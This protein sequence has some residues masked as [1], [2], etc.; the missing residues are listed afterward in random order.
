MS[1]VAMVLV[2]CS[3]TSWSQVTGYSFA[4]T[5]GTY[6]PVTAGTQIITA[7]TDDGSS[8]ATN[9]GFSFTFNGTAFTQFV[10]NSNGSIRLGSAAP[11][12]QYT[13]ISTTGNT[14]AIA[15]FA[16]D[17]Q[18]VGGV[19][20]ELS[21]TAPNRVLTIEY[22]NFAPSYLALANVMNAQIKLYE[23]TNVVQIVYGSS[24]TTASYTGQVGLRGST[25]ASDYS[26]RLSTTSW[27]ASTAGTASSSTMTWSATVQPTSGQTYTWTPPVP[28]SGTPVA[29]SVAPASQSLCTGGTVA[30]LTVSG[31]TSGVTGLTFQWIQSTDGGLNYAPVI[32]GTGATTVTY[33]PPVFAGTPI[34]YA[35]RVT[36]SNG[37]AFA[38]STPA[39]VSTPANPTTQ[40]SALAATTITYNGATLGWTNG[41]G[42]RRVV[43]LS[44]SPI[45]DPVNGNMAAYTANTVYAGTG[46]QVILDGTAATVSVTG[47][48][49]GTTYYVGVYE[50]LRC[51]AGPYD[52][53]FNTSV[54]T[55]SIS[56][57]T[58]SAVSIPYSESFETATVPN[59]AACT[60]T[61]SHPLTRST[62]ATGAAPRT[63]T[64]YQNIRWT[65][66]VT[67]YLYSAALNLTG[68][69]S[70]DMGAWYLTDGIAGWTSIKLYANTA[71]SVTGATLLTTVNNAT[72]TSYQNIN[73]TYVPGIT[74]VYYFIIEVVH[75]SGPNDM[76]IDDLYAVPTPTC[77]VPT[78]LTV[79]NVTPN[80]A[81]V[82]WTAPTTGTTPVQYEYAVT[83][84]AT[85]PTSGTI[86]TGTSDSVSGLTANTT[87]YLHVRSEC[88]LGVDYSNWVT[89]ASFT[90]PATTPA[91][92]TESFATT[93]TP[94]G[95][96]NTGF[97]IGSVANF[98]PT[99]NAIYKNLYSGAT[100]GTF[101]TINVGPVGPG[102][103]LSFQY[104]L[105]DWGTG[106][107]TIPAAGTGNFV[108][109]VSTDF[110]STYT[111]LE[112]VV[113]DGLG[114]W[115]TKSYSLASYVGQYLKVRITGN[116]ITTGDYYLAFD[117]FSV[118]YTPITVSSFAPTAVCSA[119][120]ATSVVT[121]TGTNFTGATDVQ[122]N[123]VSH[124]FAVVNDTTITVNLTGT[125]TA[126]TFTVYNIYT[127]GS[128]TGSLTI[129]ASPVVSPITG[130]SNDLCM[131][132]TL[133]LANNTALGVWSSSDTAVA[134]INTSGEVTGV[135]EGT[136]TISY[137]VTDNGCSTAVTYTVNVKAPVAITTNPVN[138]SVVTGNNI[139]FTAAAT[140][141]GVSYQWEES[142]DGG[143]SYLPISN[144]GVYSGADTAVLTLTAVPDTMNGY[145]Y[146][147]VVSGTAPCGPETTLAA[148]LTVGNTGIATH[149]SNFTLCD[150]GTATF[151][152]VGSGPVVSYQWYQDAGL[153]P[154]PLVDGAG[155]SGA[156][157]DT[158]TLTGVDTSFNGYTY[159]VDVVGPANTSPSNSATLF[160]NTPATI[161]TDPTNQ[162]V[163]YSGGTVS[164]TAAAGGTF[165]GVQWQYSTDNTSWNNVAN[166]TPAG[167][168][169]NGAT[170]A[171]LNVTTTV[172]T[173]IGGTYYY[174]ML[175]DA[176]APCF[177]VPSASAQLLFNNPA[178]TTAPAAATVLAGNTATFTVVS[179]ATGTVTYQ[180]QRSTTL[181][182][183]YSNVVNATP[184]NVTYNGANTATL[185]VIT[186][187]GATAGAN[188]YY[189]VIVTSD[190][191][192]VTST[193]A[194]LTI[195]NYCN[196]TPSSNDASG[197]T[198][199]VLGATNFTIPDVTYSNQT[200]TPV[201]FVQGSSANFQ[202]TFATGYTYDSNVWIDMNDDGDFVDAGELVK[203]GVSLAT[204][205]TT[206]NLS[207][208]MPITTPV[209]NHRMRL[210][211]ADSGQATPNPCYTGSF[212]VTIDFTVTITAA[213]QCTGTPAV[214]VAA[215][216]AS[217]TCA[218]SS[219]NLTLSGI[220]AELGYTYQWY[221]RTLPSGSFA[222]IAGATTSTY[223]YTIPAS[224]EIYAT[225]T[226]TNSGLSA[227]SNTL[228]VTTTL[229]NYTV[230][231]NTG[232]TYNSVMTTGSTYTSL[233]SADDGKT[234]TVSLAGTT[235][236][237]NG[238]VVTGFYATSNGW[239]TFNTGQTSAT[240]TNDLTSTGQ[241]NV[242]APFWDDLVI[243]GNL[244]ANRDI[245]MR[246]QVIGTLGSGSA[247][248]VIEWAEM[249]KFNYGDPNINFQIVLHEADNSIDFNYG[250]MQL[251]NGATQNTSNGYYTYSV[252]MNGSVP[253]TNATTSRIM[254]Q[255]GNNYNFA[256]TVQNSLKESPDCN[257]QL[258]FVPSAAHVSGTAPASLIPTNNE[259]AGAITL[260][261]N[262]DPCTSNCG[263]IYTSKNATATAGIGV[264]TATTPGTADDDVFFTFT[265][266]STIQN[267][268]IEVQASTNYNPVVQ[269]LDASL[270]PVACFNAA[271]AGL[272]ELVSSVTLSLST[273][274][275]LRIYDSAT[276][277]AGGASGS[278]EFAVC[279]SQILPPPAYDE[280]A[281]ALSL[282]VGTTCS[283]VASVPAEIL[284]ST[285]T[286]GI[287]VC[288]A[289]TAGTPDDDVWYKFTTPAASSGI[290][291]TI[292]VQGISTF[293]PV[294]QLFAGTP[295]TANSVAC[296]N[297]TGNGGL[298]TISNSALLPSTD[299]YVRI[300]NSGA[301]AA[302]GS[303]TVCVLAS[304]PGCVSSPTAPANASTTCES[305][306]GTTLSWAAVS[307]ATLY[308]VYFEGNLVSAD[309]TALSWTTSVL[310][311]GTYSWSV[312]PKN[313]YGT[314]TACS[315]FTFTVL[316]N[317]TYYADL[318]NDGFG[319]AAVPVVS[320][321][322]IAGYVTNN[323]DC[324]DNQVRYQDNDGDLFGSSVK[325]PC[326]GVLNSTDCNDNLLTYVDADLD[327][328]G[329]T[330]LAACGSTFN[331]DCD[332]TVASTNPGAV[333]VCYDGIDND[334]NGNIDNI[335]L[336]GGCTPIY[337]VPAVTVPNS[338][339]S[340]G[341]SIIT[342]LVA[343]C[344]GYR[345]VV[346]RVNPADD[347]PM[348]APVTVD[349]GMRNLFLSNLSNYAYGAK[350]KVET[351]VRINNVWQPNYAPA[352]FVFTPTPL[353]TVASC[354]VQISNMTTQ[355]TSSPVALVSVYRYQVQRLDASNNVLSTQVITS[356]L[357]YFSFEQVT[358]FRYDANYSVSCAI[359]NL[360]GVFMAYG[361]AC[362]IQAPKHPTSEV[363]ATQCNDYA[364]SSY[365][366]NIYANLVRNVVLYR[367]RMYN[368]SQGYDYSVDKNANYFKLTDFPGLVPGETY[369]VQVAVSMPGQPDFGP[370]GKTCTLV[371]P[372]VA[373]TIEDTQVAGAIS[374]EATVYPNPFAENFYFKVNSAS[375]E[376]YTI[377]VYDM[378][379]KLVETKTVAADSVESTEVG[380]NFP[381]GVYN[382]ILTQGANIKTL[383]VVK[384]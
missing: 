87:Y 262:N 78:A 140:G 62:T 196:S 173:P 157:T 300:Y 120:L 298:E 305:T 380:A 353:S 382:V 283:P 74:G 285:A 351:T 70:Y 124:T 44:N 293:N 247:D 194:L 8:S 100:T 344:Q 343:N 65:P 36:C 49:L 256:S 54:G 383:R 287:Q 360:D 57:T 361:P 204:N 22:T 206:L 102:M 229:C 257:S 147:C 231:R 325:V 145:F 152:V 80:T 273:Q 266:N 322:P 226:C 189:R 274:Y 43:F 38:D 141:T 277:A 42:A 264:C 371:I 276:G 92:W 289:T 60:V 208:T 359:R 364:V 17:G 105:V 345:Y 13:P 1:L 59:F 346:T 297:S 290:T 149:P 223:A 310:A 64:K 333:D 134:T 308:D 377:Q 318:D 168:T 107:T 131:P 93:T 219:I 174:R 279:I 357:R 214:P 24:T 3:F 166:G 122:L 330:T 160:V 299:Y 103:N 284:R 253:S 335:G 126:G 227:D 178:I 369:S 83:T 182:G 167:V 288:N 180:W 329:T 137:T 252:G 29:G 104:N 350:F 186:G 155:V 313:V 362:T 218:N 379:G 331:T 309:Q 332:D 192:S 11:T 280:P 16:R 110:G 113:N 303:F 354:G 355:V 336:P 312:V 81:N 161:T 302:N 199:V 249:E 125:S 133:A 106:V 144:G 179:N 142:T 321:T 12:S 32:G 217:A 50:Y 338:T 153:G 40:A 236:T 337:T 352:F 55:N 171:T 294:V 205:P 119:D 156:T 96:S 31:Y 47:L 243:K 58:C 368:V 366:E 183:T 71:P 132:N 66:T 109:E 225:I 250:N 99:T 296:V 221:S 18:A 193:G 212:G 258:R 128:S 319:N 255:N 374:F 76:S 181:N 169:Y 158:L 244:L 46:Q 184:A 67:K 88:S 378:L 5:S 191:C 9:I 246:Y 136:A 48:A 278:G 73:G 121:L 130:P 53:Y 34:L 215:T 146:Q 201:S 268:R 90:T 197:I 82:S 154:E 347:T 28:C 317:I 269:V 320:C 41:N 79:S 162:T 233:S 228:T 211:T 116:W 51:G 7:N 39:S 33:T 230:T 89:S 384:R 61:S 272:T 349:M 45:V 348:S 341:A 26:N 195:T 222:P 6:T 97:S 265:T 238:A 123:G 306:S 263:N 75:T 342:S 220:P 111:T 235:F 20:T 326:G 334:C 203:S 21:G 237:Y 242:L 185:S 84:S 339:I 291:Y 177:D 286:A 375:N 234:N 270:N 187:T 112:T 118:D 372:N 164:F 315:T 95:W 14:N 198:A 376:D 10:A 367:Y 275:Y 138:Q 135:T 327:G 85:P 129:N 159:Y 323:L 56:F 148:M 248:I 292:N 216:S 328:Y 213:P 25:T 77:I 108:V 209:G 27:S 86:V 101:S 188:N 2:L 301:G 15:L 245:S 254:L 370:F 176:T 202:V 170:T 114:G 139:S 316:P 72:N 37:G 150:N 261:V 163:C 210:G 373:R 307:S 175:A 271:G 282:T 251:F 260:A 241:N 52:Y 151:S 190:G 324:N 91:P 94:T 340:Y 4:Q 127:S 117:N 115:R 281:G 69:V 358:D 363:R 200:A 381:A 207:F 311:A 259:P 365:N 240:F 224:S 267:Y 35:C 30:A 172:T 19:F 304:V 68:S 63:G 232:I 295:S 314:A 239:M 23:T 143:I 356:G 165:S 98:A